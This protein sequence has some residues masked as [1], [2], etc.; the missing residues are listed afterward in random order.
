MTALDRYLKRMSFW[1]PRAQRSDILAE[2][3]GV[4]LERIEAAELVRG[5][6]LTSDEEQ[7]ALDDFGHPALVVS[8]YLERPPVISGG[9]AFFF[10]RVL[11][12]A[13]IGTV[14]GQAIALTIEAAHAQSL[15]PVIE[16]AVRRTLLALLL[17]FTC[18]TASFMLL[19]RRYRAGRGRAC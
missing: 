12:I 18:V 15:W 1:M 19:D 13:L 6:P 16:Q 7:D 11:A 4:L 9:L 2:L 3:R 14:V 8:R 17:A 10:W 5:R